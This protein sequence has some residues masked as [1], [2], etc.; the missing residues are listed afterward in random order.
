[1]ARAAPEPVD[2]HLIDVLDAVRRIIRVLRLSSRRIERDFGVSGAQ[3][4]VVQ[5]LARAPARSINELAERTYTHQSSVSVVV[6]RLVEQGLVVRRAASRDRR[7]R[8]LEL[9]AAGRGLATHAPVPA[10]VRLIA[11]LQSLPAAELAA[12]ARLLRRVVKGMGAEEE[13][14]TMLF[15]ERAPRASARRRPRKL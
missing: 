14:P 10:Q 3:L 7:R 5:Q 11:G 15:T 9:T 13:P 4:F 6:R 8:E 12:L 1:M 2:P